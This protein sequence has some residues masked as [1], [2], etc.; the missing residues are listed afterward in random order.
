MSKQAGAVRQHLGLPRQQIAASTKTASRHGN[1]SRRVIFFLP[2]ASREGRF[3][4]SSTSPA[5]PPL[6]IPA[7]FC[8]PPPSQSSYQECWTLAL[9]ILRNSG[10]LPHPVAHRHPAPMAGINLPPSSPTALKVRSGEVSQTPQH[11]PFL[12]EIASGQ[13]FQRRVQAGRRAACG[14]RGGE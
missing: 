4:N 1:T 12:K 5:L 3:V 9:S 6:L 10:P 8:R 14:G 13:K 11:K 7:A 2:P